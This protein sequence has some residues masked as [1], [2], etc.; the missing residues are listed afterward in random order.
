[1]E[2]YTTNNNYCFQFVQPYMELLGQL[3]L[4]AWNTPHLLTEEQALRVRTLCSLTKCEASVWYLLERT[5]KEKEREAED[6]I[7]GM[8][9]LK[10]LA[11]VREHKVRYRDDQLIAFYDNNLK[12]HSQVVQHFHSLRFRHCVNDEQEQR[13][14]KILTMASELVRLFEQ[15]AA[16][17]FYLET[18]LTANAF[19]ILK[20]HPLHYHW[21]IESYVELDRLKERQTNRVT[22]LKQALEHERANCR[23]YPQ[24]W[25]KGSDEE[26]QQ[27][28]GHCHA[29]KWLHTDESGTPYMPLELDKECCRMDFLRYILE[30]GMKGTWVKPLRPGD[31][32][33]EDSARIECKQLARELSQDFRCKIS[34]SQ[35]STARKK[36]EEA[37]KQK[38]NET[39]RRFTVPLLAK[40]LKKEKNKV[41]KGKSKNKRTN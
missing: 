37:L 34:S 21:L 3:T 12:D 10:T 25:W 14:N 28:I 2:N 23:P 31:E 15:D 29:Q 33:H 30:L 20:E 13:A 22:E 41:Q 19:R 35:I 32:R 26:W 39:K 7:K 38:L 1:M 6:G 18:G 27:F 4:I 16:F 24:S 5:R 17:I 9:V 8:D 36:M 40:A 11:R